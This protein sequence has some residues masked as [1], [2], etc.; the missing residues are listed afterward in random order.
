MYFFQILLYSF[1]QTNMK[2]INSYYYYKLLTSLKNRIYQ[3]TKILCK[4]TQHDHMPNR[5]TVSGGMVGPVSVWGPFKPPPF[6]Q[7]IVGVHV[8]FCGS[9]VYFLSSLSDHMGWLV[10]ILVSS[11][12]PPFECRQPADVVSCGTDGIILLTPSDS[13]SLCCVAIHLKLFQ[14]H[15]QCELWITSYSRHLS[16]SRYIDACTIFSDF[17][18]EERVTTRLNK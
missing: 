1:L 14:V 5:W 11:S 4:Y 10:I 15:R 6:S 16:A 18:E 9:S 13:Q 12:Y 8:L 17:T 7:C 2:N 3:E